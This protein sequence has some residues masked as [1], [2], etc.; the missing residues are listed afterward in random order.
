[1][2]L[3][4]FCHVATRHP[5][6]NKLERGGSD[7]KEGDDVWVIQVLPHHSPLVERLHV[8]LAVVAGD[9]G[10]TYFCGFP[11]TGFR[12]HPNAFDTNL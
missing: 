3:D 12:V 7:A 10:I 4:V 6:R 5:F 8:R 11:L 1:M 2:L 9:G